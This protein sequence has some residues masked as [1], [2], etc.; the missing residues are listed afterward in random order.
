MIGML[1]EPMSFF[2]SWVCQGRTV[3]N[4]LVRTIMWRFVAILSVFIYIHV[5]PVQIEINI[6][7]A[8][9][10]AYGSNE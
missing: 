1:D 4:I 8:L 2:E 9:L 10:H 7:F 3:H 6:L 5:A